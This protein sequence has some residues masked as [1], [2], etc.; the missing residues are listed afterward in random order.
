M[1]DKT[2]EQCYIFRK[3]TESVPGNGIIKEKSITI[4][5]KTLKEVEKIFNK[6]KKEVFKN[7]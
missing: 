2:E 4:Q 7:D 1:S 5:G 6:Q 3:E